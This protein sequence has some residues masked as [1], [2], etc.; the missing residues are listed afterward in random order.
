LPRNERQTIEGE[1]FG[2]F[3]R[4]R[5]DRARVRGRRDQLESAGADYD[6]A[7]EADKPRLLSR[8]RA[9]LGRAVQRVEHLHLWWPDLCWANRDGNLLRG[10]MGYPTSTPLQSAPAAAPA[11]VRTE[12]A[13]RG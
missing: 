6:A 1:A 3:V 12:S 10:Q 5:R 11:S 7:A 13:S 8:V 9:V 4:R 2:S